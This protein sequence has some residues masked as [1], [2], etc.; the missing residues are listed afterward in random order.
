MHVIS[1]KCLDVNKGDEASPNY[2][3]RL[4][5]REI[6]RE[7][8]DDL[9]AATPPF[10][11]LKALFSLA[12]SSQGRME[13][14]RV[15]AIDVKRAYFYAPAT[16][17]LFIQIPRE[18]REVGDEGKVARLLLSIYGTRDAA[19]NWT[20]AYTNFALSIGFEKGKGC[21]CN[22]YQKRGLAMTVHGDDFT[23]TGST[24]NL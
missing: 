9:S 23:S 21:P 17:P 22:F 14:Y 18:D 11:S 16:R 2:R 15:M 20:A 7:K 3:A 8:R 24:K 6:A 5:G 12:A 1:T 19:M 13:P 4:V 10:E